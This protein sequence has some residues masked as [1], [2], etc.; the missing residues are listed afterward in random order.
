MDH[1]GMKGIPWDLFM[2]NRMHGTHKWT[3]IINFL[4]F[5]NDHFKRLVQYFKVIGTTKTLKSIV[6]M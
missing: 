1:K 6:A 3:F 4:S 2:F 5:S